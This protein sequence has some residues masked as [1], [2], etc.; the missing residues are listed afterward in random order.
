MRLLASAYCD[1]GASSVRGEH[2]MTLTDLFTAFAGE[3]RDVHYECR[4]CGKNLGGPVDQ[5]P[6]C[7][8]GVCRYE[9][10]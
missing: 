3:E 1:A 6:V 2:S 5:C 4:H 9:F 8:R 7:G 10:E